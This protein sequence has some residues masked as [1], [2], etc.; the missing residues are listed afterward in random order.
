MGSFT[1]S[2]EGRLAISFKSPTNAFDPAIPLLGAYPEETENWL[3][4]NVHE[5]PL[6]IYLTQEM[7]GNNLNI[8]K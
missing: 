7:L 2:L 3:K 6:Q 4:I 5:Y 8:L 1:V